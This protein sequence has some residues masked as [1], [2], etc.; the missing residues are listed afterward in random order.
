MSVGDEAEGSVPVWHQKD[1]F[2]LLWR[3]LV[4]FITFVWPSHFIQNSKQKLKISLDACY[5]MGACVHTPIFCL[6]YVCICV[7]I[8]MHIQY[9]SV[10][11]VCILIC[12]IALRNRYCC[13]ANIWVHIFDYSVF[14][15]VL[16]ALHELTHFILTIT[17]WNRY[18]RKLRCR[19][20][21]TQGHTATVWWNQGSNPGSLASQLVLEPL[22]WAACLPFPTP[23]MKGGVTRQWNVIQTWNKKIGCKP[24]L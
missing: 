13:M 9:L 10:Y 19:V 12:P 24:W 20:S 4:N 5:I 3:T 14:V 15:A 18:L 2:L 17:L 7:C 16:G 1:I 22:C 8:Y 23:L 11:I 6:Y 21:Y